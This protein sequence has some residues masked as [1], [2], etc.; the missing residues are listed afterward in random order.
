MDASSARSGGR[1][2]ASSSRRPELEQAEERVP[3]ILAENRAHERLGLLGEPRRRPAPLR[4]LSGLLAGSSPLGKTAQEFSQP[5]GFGVQRGLVRRGFPIPEQAQ[6][7]A[8]LSGGRITGQLDADSGGKRGIAEPLEGYKPGGSNARRTRKLPGTDWWSAPA[9]G[10][11]WPG[12]G[13]RRPVRAGRGG[14]G[15]SNGCGG[16]RQAGR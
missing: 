3:S 6:Q 15:P 5:F 7:K 4:Q 1:P 8:G 13:R 2:Y 11:S 9:R 10:G 16:S 14:S 12:P